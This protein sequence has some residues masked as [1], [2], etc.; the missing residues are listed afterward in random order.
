MNGLSFGSAKQGVSR[1]QVN[2]RRSQW[3]RRS[4]QI[5]FFLFVFSVV[6]SHYVERRG[7]E[8]PWPVLGNFHALCPFG[9]VE[10]AGR[11]LLDGALIP[12]I[13]VSN[14]WVFGSL[15]LLTLV[16][17]SA[18][19]GYLCPLGS[20]QEWTGRLGRLLFRKF[21]RFSGHRLDRVLG[22]MRYGVL[23]LILVQT[24][25]SLR[26]VFQR[27]DP[28]YA[29][30]HFWTGDVFLSAVIVLGVVLILSL[31]FERP[32]CRWFCPLGALLGLVQRVSF[33]KIRRQKDVCSGC[34]KCSRACPMGITVARIQCVK[35]SRCNCCGSCIDVCGRK[36]ALLLSG[37]RR[38]V[39]APLKSRIVLGVL[40]LSLFFLPIVSAITGGYFNS[41][42]S[43]LERPGTLTLQDI[44]GSM[45][46]GEM[47]RGLRMDTASLTAI[48]GIPPDTPDTTKMYDL[49]E[50]DGELT[51]GQVKDRL[52]DHM[53][54]RGS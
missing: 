44:R 19:C 21:N 16:L 38:G 18:F 24:T 9:A 22:F 15:I 25:L 54:K 33:L 34:G 14:F 42:A 53:E 13:R 52:S 39:F 31:F 17:G 36:G 28:F 40:V 29:L 27:V 51:I 26:L 3:V 32:W 1:V 10:S 30:F 48:L 37:P 20:A 5:L 7:L 4:V 2:T 46:L 49:E 43:K 45:T 35:D 12:K 47:A 6:L 8:L 50:I 41:S 23:I 11:L